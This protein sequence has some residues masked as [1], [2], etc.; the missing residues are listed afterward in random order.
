[1]KFF[2]NGRTFTKNQGGTL[3]RLLEIVLGKSSNKVSCISKFLFSMQTFFIKFF[4]GE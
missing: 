1:M 2:E 4:L 3:K